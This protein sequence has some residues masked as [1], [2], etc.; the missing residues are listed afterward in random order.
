MT[1]MVV[2]ESKESI[3]KEV[4][5]N[6]ERTVLLL[7]FAQDLKRGLSAGSIEDAFMST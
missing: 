5:E 6:L 3:K 7:K 4:V 1:N 2:Q